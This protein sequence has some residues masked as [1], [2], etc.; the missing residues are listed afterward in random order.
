MGASRG[1]KR[2]VW[3]S[4]C[5]GKF[6]GKEGCEGMILGVGFGWEPGGTTAGVWV[7]GGGGGEV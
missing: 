4:V 5:S 7:R 1:G 2:G 3:V 6:E